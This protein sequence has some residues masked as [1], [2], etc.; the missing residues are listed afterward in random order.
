M[1]ISHVK[2]T[3]LVHTYD[4]VNISNERET[5]LLAC[6]MYVLYNGQ[7]QNEVN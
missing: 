6:G 1:I 7:Q 2:Q 5:K 4:A 3:D